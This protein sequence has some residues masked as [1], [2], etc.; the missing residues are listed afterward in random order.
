MTSVSDI[1]WLF[2]RYYSDN[3]QLRRI[4]TVHSEQVAKK[5]LSILKEKNLDLNPV[6]VYCAAMLHDIGVVKCYAPNIYAFGTM[7]YIFH[8][9]EGRKILEKHHL[10]KYASVCDSHTGAGISRQ[11]IIKN[12]ILLPH[13]DFLPVTQLEKLICYSDKFFS[14]SKDLAYEKSPNEI[15]SE[16]EKFGKDSVK[17]FLEL[18]SLFGVSP[19]K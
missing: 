6:D 5:A 1:N 7:P 11:D 10:H 13:K 8:G 18:H 4:V 16:L 19:N 17:R 15:I 2:S 9:I 14:K 3:P 12:N